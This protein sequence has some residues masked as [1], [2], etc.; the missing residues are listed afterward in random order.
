M[1][2][3]LLPCLMTFAVV[4]LPQILLAEDPPKPDRPNPESLLKHLDA[5]K[6]GV[7][8]ADEIPAGIPERLKQLLIKADKDGN[9]TITLDEL[10]AVLKDRKPPK[11]PEYRPGDR[12]EPNLESRPFPGPQVRPG[13][14]WGQVTQRSLRATLPELPNLKA[15]FDRLD[16]DKD[17]KLSFDEF[18]VGVMKLHS[19]F[20]MHQQSPE[21]S[22]HRMN[23]WGRADGWQPGPWMAMRQAGWGQEGF[24]GPQFRG[25]EWF[26]PGPQFQRRGMGMGPGSQF[27]GRG[28]GFGPPPYGGARGMGFGPPPFWGP[29]PQSRGPWMTEFFGR[30]PQF[31]G[32]GW[33]FGTQSH[34]FAMHRPWG[35][36]PQFFGYGMHWPHQRHHGQYAQFW[37]GHHGKSNMHRQ[38]TNGKEGEEKKQDQVVEKKTSESKFSE[39]KTTND[40]SPEKKEEIVK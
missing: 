35:P 11:G 24:H 40:N 31:Q 12:P 15:I 32:H 7:I 34:G 5:N 19:L 17:G 36:G 27:Q 2:K 1:R 9:K 37:G 3:L 20:A 4:A 21:G 39:K 14:E 33:G 38:H 13:M 6:D 8:T 25:P 23:G 18:K 16:T 30:G 26:G 28:M 10:K 29:G 22:V